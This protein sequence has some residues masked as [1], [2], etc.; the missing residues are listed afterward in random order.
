MY[1][2]ASGSYGKRCHSFI[3]KDKN[4]NFLFLLFL[5]DCKTSN[6]ICIWPEQ[7][8]YKEQSVRLNNL[9]K[10][11]DTKWCVN[12]EWRLCIHSGRNGAGSKQEKDKLIF[13]NYYSPII[14]RKS[15][16][17]QRKRRNWGSRKDDRKEE[18][19]KGLI[20]PLLKLKLNCTKIC[21]K[22]M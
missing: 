10:L 22:K 8:L 7:W 14:K 19:E 11:I 1:C 20:K 6:H 4:G 3:L 21:V 2:R 12:K 13:R 5:G 17:K 15:K 9:Y 18:E 16:G